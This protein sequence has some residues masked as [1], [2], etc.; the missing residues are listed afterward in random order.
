MQIEFSTAVNLLIAIAL[1]VWAVAGTI[2]GI[3]IKIGK[4]EKNLV[5]KNEL[6]EHK[7]NCPARIFLRKEGKIFLLLFGIISLFFITGCSTTTTTVTEFNDVGK[8]TKTTVTTEKDAFDKVTQSTQN[9]TIIMWSNGWA[10]YLTASM[11]TTEDPT[12]SI[13]IYAGKIAK[14]YISLKDNQ[15]LANVANV[16]TATKETLNVDAQGIK[17]EVQNE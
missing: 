8:I 7:K 16:I 13:K 10:A 11:A 6:K 2:L 5:S 9:K 17:N 1:G 12:P 3:W 14:G 4:L 15:K